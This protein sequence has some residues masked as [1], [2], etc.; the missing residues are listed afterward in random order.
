MYS[1]L[2]VHPLTIDLSCFNRVIYLWVWLPVVRYIL[3]EMQ[4]HW[5]LHRIRKQRDVLTDSGLTPLAAYETAEQRGQIDCFVPVSQE[6]IDRARETVL[7]QLDNTV[8]GREGVQFYTTG[9]H[10]LLAQIWNRIGAPHIDRQ[11]AWDVFYQILQAVHDFADDID[12]D[13]WLYSP[14]FENPKG[15]EDSAE[16][17][18]LSDETQ[19]DGG[20]VLAGLGLGESPSENDD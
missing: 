6:I 4:D 5:N 2:I 19:S 15:N 11:N 12:G 16:D 9:Q 10:Q 14:D 13:V 7:A 1:S 8:Y 3:G 17:D 18:A 20:I